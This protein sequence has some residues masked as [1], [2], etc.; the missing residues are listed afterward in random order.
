M[1]AIL[2]VLPERRR[3]R[4]LVPEIKPLSPWRLVFSFERQNGWLGS[5]AGYFGAARFA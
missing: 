1:S 3:E 4:E 2:Y 5:A